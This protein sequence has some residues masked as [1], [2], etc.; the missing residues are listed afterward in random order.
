MLKCLNFV[1]DDEMINNLY[2]SLYIITVM[3]SRRMRLWDISRV[4]QMNNK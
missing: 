4:E 1:A 3:K 2:F